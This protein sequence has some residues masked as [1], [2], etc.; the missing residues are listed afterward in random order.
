MIIQ[1]R[2]KN[3]KAHEDIDLVDIPMVAVIIGQNN[4]GKSA[5]LQAAGTARYG[6][7]DTTYLPL[8]ALPELVRAG[9][10]AG[11]VEVYFKGAPGPAV[12]G[13]KGSGVT[14]QTQINAKFTN[15]IFYISWIRFPARNFP[16]E[17]YVPEV[18]MA[19][20]KTW[21]ILHQLKAN[22]DPRLKT[23][24]KWMKNMGMG[25][26][27]MTTPTAQPG[28]GR[29]EIT[30]YGTRT[31]LVLQGS[32]VSSVLPI[33]VQGVLCKPG[34]TLLLE[35]PDAHLHRAAL[36]SLLRFFG[37]CASRGVQV[38]CTS[39]SLD[40]LASMSE[41]IESSEIPQDS[42]IYFLKRDAKGATSVT[43]YDPKV[44]RNISQVIKKALA[45]NPV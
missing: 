31:N 28:Y 35:E 17:Q 16:Y 40:L 36:N 12:V 30:S 27:A 37:D 14:S 42:T 33:V 39:H 43:T 11:A 32:G 5:I 13:L 20:E 25:M 24:R 34:S 2:L 21:D 4:T 41:R 44:F 15:S 23:I 45:A 38:I 7:L 1:I 6:T 18:G 9:A 26:S 29:L 22:D 8:G 10:L 3:F 19:G